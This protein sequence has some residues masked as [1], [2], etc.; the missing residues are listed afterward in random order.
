M[1]ERQQLPDRRPHVTQKV[2][3]GNCRTVYL[4]TH[5]DA[6]PRELFVRVKGLDCTSEIVGL[7]DVLARW[8]KVQQVGG[9]A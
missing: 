4:S 5:A 9:A 6:A 2:R 3:V 7:Y 8:E 1:T